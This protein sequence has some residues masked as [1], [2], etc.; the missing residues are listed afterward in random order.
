MIC[1]YLH[2]LDFCSK[3][4]T[5]DEVLGLGSPIIPGVGLGQEPSGAMITL[6][7]M[8]FKPTTIRTWI[9]TDN[10]LTNI[11]FKMHFNYYSTI[12]Y[13]N[14]LF[15]TVGTFL[16]SLCYCHLSCL[17]SVTGRTIWTSWRIKVDFYRWWWQQ[18]HV[19]SSGSDL[20]CRWAGVGDAIIC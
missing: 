17:H 19:A 3:W 4:C 14:T 15:K 12:T 11:P 9:W 18:A 20:Y 6:P 13:L 8:G 5:S 7:T 1:I 10:L 16:Y 2:T